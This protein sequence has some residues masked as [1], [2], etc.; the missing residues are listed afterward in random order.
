MPIGLLFIYVNIIVLINN[1][2][3]KLYTTIRF[4]LMNIEWKNIFFGKLKIIFTF[5][6]NRYLY[7]K[8]Y[9]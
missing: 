5:Q 9:I 7:K 4:K 2:I 8:K 3:K 6:R 1:F